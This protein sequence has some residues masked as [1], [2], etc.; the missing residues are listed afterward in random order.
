MITYRVAHVV[1][2]HSWLKLNCALKDLPMLNLTHFTPLFAIAAK[3]L[4]R[5][6][7]A[8][9]S[10]GG[11][12]GRFC[13][14]NLI[15]KGKPP[16]SGTL[17]FWDLVPS[18]VGF[19]IVII[20]YSQRMSS[21][22]KCFSSSSRWITLYSMLT[23]CGLGSGRRGLL[24]PNGAV[25]VEYVEVARDPKSDEEDLIWVPGCNSY[26]LNKSSLLSHKVRVV[27]YECLGLGIVLGLSRFR[28]L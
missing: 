25:E 12:E 3:L 28:I 23:R 7:F 6:H 1:V 2:E 8:G 27:E 15:T 4:H 17:S 22:N 19:P 20:H 21:V 14:K 5:L 24:V 26:H 18:V 16:P 9:G 11:L 10:L 13:G